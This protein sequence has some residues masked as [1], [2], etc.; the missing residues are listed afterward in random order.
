MEPNGLSLSDE[1]ANLKRERT[2]Q[3]ATDLF[4]L[5]GYTN[6]TLEQV[7][8]TL[9]VTKP[10]IYKNFG[11]KHALLA[12]IC[13]T[14]VQGAIDE[15]DWA[16]ANAENA[17]QVLKLFLPRY[18]AT[19]I[20]RQKS[21]AIN[22]REEK[23]LLPN[24]AQQLAKLRTEF[25]AKVQEVLQK[26]Q[27]AGEIEVADA[28]VAAFAIVGAVSWTTFWFQNDGPLSR[29]QVATQITNVLLNLVASQ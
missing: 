28:R 21:I 2:L 14:G 13:E 19:I 17:G 10:F 18:V 7:A 8:T 22:I 12:E 3:A 15:I 29:D 20:D 25:M 16:M 27:Q 24:D 6:T 11:S 1:V 4:Y 9:G 5:Q 23:N 26:G